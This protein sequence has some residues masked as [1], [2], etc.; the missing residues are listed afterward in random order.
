MSA[1]KSYPYPLAMKIS[2]LLYPCHVVSL[3]VTFDPHPNHSF[4]NRNIIL[5]DN[6]DKRY[7]Y[8]I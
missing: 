5:A 7:R 8:E 3:Q 6:G 4:T 2:L 1:G